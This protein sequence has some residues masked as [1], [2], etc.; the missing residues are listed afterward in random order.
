[1]KDKIIK[2]LNNH[3]I[4][5]CIEGFGNNSEEEISV[6][7]DE[8]I[9]LF[10]DEREYPMIDYEAIATKHKSLADDGWVFSDM[11]ENDCDCQHCQPE[12]W[13]LDTDRDIWIKK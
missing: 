5:I 9:A 4:D 7:A 12:L 1:M 6:I 8:I 3:A 11:S 13:I 2:I 10:E